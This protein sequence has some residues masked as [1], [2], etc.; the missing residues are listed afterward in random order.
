MPHW[1]TTTFGA[2][3]RHDGIAASF[4]LDDPINGECFLAYVKEVLAPALSPGDIFLIDNSPLAQERQSQG[5]NRGRGAE[6]RFLPRTSPDLNPIDLS[7]SSGDVF[8]I[9][10]APAKGLGTIRRSPV[11]PHRRAP[12]PLPP[13]RVRK[14]LQDRWIWTNLTG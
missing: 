9:E 1:K 7:A 8:E 3:L 4:V 12:R 5:G 14:L 10:D 13:E 6:L 11:E 2:A